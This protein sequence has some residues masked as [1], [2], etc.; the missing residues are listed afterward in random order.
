MIVRRDSISNHHNGSGKPTM[1]HE[2]SILSDTNNLQR[3]S[4]ACRARLARDPCD[5]AARLALSWHLFF[6]A[7]HQKHH[8][9]FWNRLLASS[10]LQS[11]SF[12]DIL[13]SL[14]AQTARHTPDARRLFHDSLMQASM[15]LQLSGEAHERHEAAKILE[16]AGIL[17]ESQVAVEVD[18]EANKILSRVARAICAEKREKT[19][20]PHRYREDEDFDW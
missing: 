20:I 2:Q 14:H 12:R 7:L 11:E 10:E 3:L 6:Q 9:L 18:A 13:L 15:V 19:R 1:T 17:G 5:L 8:Q 4:A 16:L